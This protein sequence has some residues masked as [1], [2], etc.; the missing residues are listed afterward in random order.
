MMHS[1]MSPAERITETTDASGSPS[2]GVKTTFSPYPRSSNG[3]LT[4]EGSP[5]V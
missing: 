4:M 1:S 5:A 2:G 3:S